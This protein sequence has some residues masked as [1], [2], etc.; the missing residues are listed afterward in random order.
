[1]VFIIAV[2]ACEAAIALALILM[3]ARRSGKLDVAVWHALRE[4]DQ[5]AFT[6][7]ALPDEH[8]A[9]REPMPRL[10]PAGLTPE[11]PREETEYRPRV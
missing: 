9:P 6:E 3:L 8:V 1:V 10:T 7:D 11:V 2:A 5:P 4:A